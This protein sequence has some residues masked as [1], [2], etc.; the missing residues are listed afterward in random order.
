MQSGTTTHNIA[1]S[2]AGLLVLM[3]ATTAAMMAWV[4][5]SEPSMIVTVVS[6]ND[7]KAIVLVVFEVL[8]EAFSTLIQYL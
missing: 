2:A 7:A 4:L 5:T 1:M 8:C 6:G 3:A